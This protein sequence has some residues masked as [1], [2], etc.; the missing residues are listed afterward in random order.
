MF[1]VNRM[2]SNILGGA[3]E[4]ASNDSDT[5]TPALRMRSSAARG[6]ARQPE[7]ELRMSRKAQGRVGPR[8]DLGVDL[9]RRD[10]MADEQLGAEPSA[11]FVARGVDDI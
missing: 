4:L 10:V 6:I 1:Q 7:A 5:T 8:H 9:A 3:I 2:V 11:L